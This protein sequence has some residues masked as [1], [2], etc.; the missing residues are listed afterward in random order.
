MNRL[1][2]NVNDQKS[3]DKK[4]VRV[5]GQ[6]VPWGEP[7]TIPHEVI[8]LVGDQLDD[9]RDVGS[10]LMAIGDSADLT[11]EQESLSLENAFFKRTSSS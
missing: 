4:F 6:M 8:A 5:T 10:L 3:P 7:V 2:G 9:P 11:I 1:N